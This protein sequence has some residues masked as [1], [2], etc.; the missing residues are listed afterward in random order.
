MGGDILGTRSDGGPDHVA[1]HDLH[2]LGAF[3]TAAPLIC[4]HKESRWSFALLPRRRSTSDLTHN[5]RSKM[6]LSLSESGWG[7]PL[8]GGTT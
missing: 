6:L 8:V 5:Q 2:T 4:A 3:T 1:I 7:T